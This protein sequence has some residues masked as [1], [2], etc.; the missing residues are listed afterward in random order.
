[1][2]AEPAK[3]EEECQ[4][5]R[6]VSTRLVAVVVLAVAAAAASALGAG[7]PAEARVACPVN[8]AFRQPPAPRPRYALTVRVHAGLRRVTGSLR[9]TFT[10]ERPT[11][12]VVFR[13]W[14]NSPFLGNKGARL[15]VGSVKLDGANAAVSR[16]DPTTLVLTRAIAANATVRV[17]MTFELRLP[18]G[19]RDRLYGGGPAARFGSFF[20]LLAWDPDEGWQ[21]DPPSAIGWEAWTSPAADF[22]VTVSAPRGLQVLASGDRV[23]PT[24][25]RAHGIRDF[26]LAVGRFVVVRDTAAAPGPVRVVVAVE[27]RDRSS[28]GRFLAWTR[29]ALESHAR[30]FGPYP[31]KTFT[32]V[33]M[34]MDRFSYEYPTLVFQSTT[35]PTPL[36]GTA[37]EVAHQWFYSLVGNNQSRDPWLD[38]TLAEWGKV[39][40]AG[41]LAAAVANPMAAPARRQ[42]GQPMPFWDRF[43]IP[44]LIDGVYTQGV[45]A[46]ASLGE[47][48]VVDCALRLYA[49]QNAYGIA[50]PGDLLR[51][52]ETFF[53]DARQKLEA[54]GAHF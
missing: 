44:V 20:P 32:L 41:I 1:L 39:R 23:A 45:Q 19:S 18:G 54:F 31:W 29:A 16:P 4:T 8:A 26:A 21:T 24:R 25:W 11:D 12:R 52:L 2:F 3:L 42:L 49:A 38:E 28:A 40:F 5:E 36:K 37:H 51:A 43:P 15:T 30:R 47:P 13:L 46:L 48:N 22:E 35:D 14:A 34:D 6:G 9:V 33:G 27:P 17:S 7:G 53:P 50:A 10:P